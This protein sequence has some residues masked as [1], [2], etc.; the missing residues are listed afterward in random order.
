[1][2]LL[3]KYSFINLKLSQIL[4]AKRLAVW[5]LEHNGVNL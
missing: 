4:I 1:M 5:R 3:T 2:F